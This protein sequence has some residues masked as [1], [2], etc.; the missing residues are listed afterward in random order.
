MTIQIKLSTLF[1]LFVWPICPLLG[2]PVAI[3]RVKEWGAA[4]Y[5]VTA[6]S[7]L[8]L[9]LAYAAVLVLSLIPWTATV[10]H[11]D[12]EVLPVQQNHVFDPPI[13]VR[14]QYRTVIEFL[15][16][17]LPRFDREFVRCDRPGETWWID[18][19]TKKRVDDRMARW[20][21]CAYKRYNGDQEKRDREE[22]ETIKAILEQLG[23]SQ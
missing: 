7:S 3:A 9:T 15:P 18:L 21:E 13:N 2:L 17:S 14:I 16:W 22:A 20:S 10:T 19:A 1:W 4:K 5:F 6:F 8:F 23:E 11:A 12:L